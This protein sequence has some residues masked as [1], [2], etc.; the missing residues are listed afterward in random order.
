MPHSQNWWT[1]MERG[2]YETTGVSNSIHPNF[3][4]FAR[5]RWK[6]GRNMW[7]DWLEIQL[8]ITEGEKT[9]QVI[10]ADHVHGKSARSLKKKS[11]SSM[12]TCRFLLFINSKYGL[13]ILKC[14]YMIATNQYILSTT[15]LF[16]WTSK[17]Y[18]P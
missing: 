12:D 9:E 5:M 6:H 7:D 2:H 14:K 3:G 1:G 11:W 10:F 13:N 18:T 8:Y 16:R 17:K 15:I 4:S